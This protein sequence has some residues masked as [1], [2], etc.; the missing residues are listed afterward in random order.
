MTMT[1]WIAY[2]MEEIMFNNDLFHC[3]FC[4]KTKPMDE[5]ATCEGPEPICLDCHDIECITQFDCLMEGK[6]G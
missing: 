5:R 4:E 2:A 1:R 3:A 6:F